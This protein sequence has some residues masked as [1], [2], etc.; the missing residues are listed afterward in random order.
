[1]AVQI[2]NIEN[3]QELEVVVS[4]PDRANR[5]FIYTGTA[6]FEF[7][8]TGGDWRRDS[9]S[10]PIGRTF[11]PGQFIRAIATASLASIFNQNVANNAG[12]AVESVDA[13]WD[14]ESGQVQLSAQLAVRDSDGFLN[15]IAYQASVLAA[16]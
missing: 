2:I 9:I 8:G 14:D 3:S 6:V 5:L 1:M 12:W 7:K 4:G 15:R 16:I 11:Q 13:D 10:F